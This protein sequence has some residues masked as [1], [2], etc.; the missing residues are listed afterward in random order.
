MASRHSDELDRVSAESHAMTTSARA[1][2]EQSGKQ[3]K[4]SHQ[5]VACSLELLRQNFTKLHD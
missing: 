5:V 4:W 3:I 2:C 1:A